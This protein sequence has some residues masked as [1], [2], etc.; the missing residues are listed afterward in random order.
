MTEPEL[1]PLGPEDGRSFLVLSHSVGW[2]FSPAE[3]EFYLTCGTFVGHRAGERLISSAGLFP[4]G[5]TFA[6]LGLVMVHPE[7]QRQ[8]LGRRLVRHWL[9]EAGRRGLPISLIASAA[10]YR[11]YLALNST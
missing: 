5:S 1:L 11:L 4:Y 7:H 10:G 6:F 9:G 3:V 2:S 8:G